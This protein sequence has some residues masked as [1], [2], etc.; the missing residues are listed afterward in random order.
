MGSGYGIQTALV[1]PRI[2]AK[3]HDIIIGTFGG[4]V[5]A[6]LNWDGMTVL[7]AG[8]DAYGSDVIPAHAYHAQAD[9]LIT[10]MDAWALNGSLM[11]D[12]PLAAWMPIDTGRRNQDGSHDSIP[13][14]GDADIGFLESSGAIPIAMSRW[15]EQ[16]LKNH[17]Y[18]PLYI[19]H[20]VDTSVFAP[21]ADR[22]ELR[23]KAGLTGKFAIVM[24]AANKDAIRKCFFEQF[25]AFGR[26]QREH[27]P[28]AVLLVHTLATNAGAPDLMQM[29]IECGIK[30]YVH[31]SNQYR[32]LMGL[33]QP[34]DIAALLN[35]AD[36]MSNTSMGEGFGVTPLEGLACG[37]PA[38]LNKCA[39]ATEMALGPEWLTDNQPFWNPTHNARWAT[40]KIDSIVE[41]YCMA[42]QALSDPVQAQAIRSQAREKALR[43][44]IGHV[45]EEY[46]QPALTEIFARLD[47]R[48]AKK[49]AEA[50]AEVKDE[51]S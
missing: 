29:A 46:W 33:F 45:V 25:E 5:G 40:P 13:G 4:L 38:V 50:D 24:N 43:Y 47:E 44:D 51:L 42:Y 6:P 48:K 34:A 37:V 19:P 17:D 12:V 14:I 41:A 3:G 9:L 10:L 16:A 1:A 11:K 20:A 7:P 30:E 49:A 15:G 27:C 36:V 39:A 18:D 8:Q 31:F 21:R 22:E 35:T 2:K 32:T 26:F 28:E 23:D